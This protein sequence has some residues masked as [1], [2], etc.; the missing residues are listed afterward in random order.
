MLK[1]IK[2]INLVLFITF[3]FF[4]TLTCKKSSPVNPDENNKIIFT[5]E[6]A[7]CTEAWFNLKINDLQF[8]VRVD[9]YKDNFLNKSLNVF[10]STD[11]TF[12]IEDLLPKKKYEVYVKVKSN[13]GEELT[14]ERINFETMDTTS[15]NFSWQS[16]EFGTIGSSTLYDVAII[17]ENDIWAVGEINIADTSINGYTTYN[18][19]H[20]DGTKWELKR[21]Y[22]YS[23]C[24]SIDYAP[25]RSIYA[26]ASN[27][28][29]VTSGGGM[30]WFD[31]NRWIAEC[32]INPLL[33]GAINKL[34]GS[35]SED[36]YAV[37]NNGNIVHWDGVRWTRI[38]SGTDLQFLDIYGASCP[39]TGELT[40]LAVC[41]RNNPLGKGIYKIAGNTSTEI[42]Y[43]PIQ[44]E[45]WSVWFVPNRHY[46]VVGSGIYEKITLS[47]S[48][49]KNGPLDITHYATTC[50]RGNGLN[51][52][53]IVGAFGELLHFNGFRWKSFI[54]QLG[55]FNGSYTSVAVNDN[56]V[57]VVGGNMQ[58]AKVLI[59][60][61]FN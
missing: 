33:T 1:I 2:H 18:A 16:W 46:Y 8:P 55:W 52:V 50:I 28:I 5:F 60:K 36:L 35:S 21:I 39:K 43:Y 45:L 49:W 37:G 32:S 47:D 4:T 41:T 58:K 53:F 24:S 11:T 38:E 13:N 59:G 10:G 31:G 14:S 15:H 26:F 29:V 40:I 19:V 22:T 12:Y 23:K 7:S 42:S 48:F 9:L 25:L 3:F 34:W 6:D 61:K 51:D 30:W 17:D 56:L 20:W 57:C 44:W 54:D 27:K